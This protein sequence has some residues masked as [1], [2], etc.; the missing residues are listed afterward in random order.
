MNIARAAYERAFRKHV[1]YRQCFLGDNGELTAA[2]KIVLADLAKFGG[3]QSGPTV[4]SPISR[5]TD[6][7][8]TM[9]RVGR[10]DVF[11]RIWRYL[12]LDTNRM[13]DNIQEGVNPDG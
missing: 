1:A 2:A 13:I 11:F 9:Q 12:R 6:V 5:T 10:V 7:P 4:V 8:A 3:L